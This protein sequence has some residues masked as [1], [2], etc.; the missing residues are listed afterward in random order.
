[1]HEPASFPAIRCHLGDWAYYSTVLPFSEVASRIQRATEI[2]TN[3][4]L[5]NMIQRE[6]GIRVGDIAD[7]VQMQ[8]ER[9][10]NAIV[11]GVYGGAPDWF[12]IGI[13]DISDPQPTNLSEHRRESLGILQLS[14]T[15]K[16]FAVDGQ[17][18]VEGIKRA[19]SKEPNLGS[20][21]LVVLFVAHRDTPEGTARTR[22]L[23]TTLNKYAKRV[24]TNEII[25]LDEDDAFAVVTRM[26]V[27][28]Y[29][30]LN[31]TAFAEGAEISLVKFKGAQIPRGDSYSIT[32]IQT[33]YKLLQILSVT[34][35]Y[36]KKSKK[37]L[38]QSRP[39]D[40]IIDAMYR[41]HEQFWEELR[42]HVPAMRE[43]LSSNPRERMAEKHRNRSGGHILFRPV[44]QVT[45]A[46]ALRVLLD[47]GIP[48]QQGVR[49]L[50]NTQL[51]LS[52]H[53]WIYVMWDPSRKAMNRTNLRLTV[54]LLLYMAH[55]QLTIPM[56]QLEELYQIAVGNPEA[57]LTDI[58]KGQSARPL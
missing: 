36:S 33:L 23:F 15:E 27:N 5:N 6:L 18:R 42:E 22:R 9:F 24:T 56:N 19:L 50:A 30:G 58:P 41:A 10:F 32:T 46:N 21:E 13:D 20:E 53:P 29:D 52:Q 25:A 40:E 57:K 45:F 54:N 7:Y 28:R 3:P 47:R 8:P 35:E 49:A 26:I 34:T 44:G 1:M 48:V 12:P 4:G 39:S 17:H 2:N 37:E 43:S 16:L 31:K 14:G 38:T 51:M 55:Q 11:V